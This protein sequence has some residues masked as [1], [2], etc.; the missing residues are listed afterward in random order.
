MS[1][2]ISE[3]AVKAAMDAHNKYYGDLAIYPS[4]EPTPEGAFHEAL[5]AALPF[6][7][8]QGAVKKLAW[9]RPPLSDTL[10]RCDTDFG[11]YRTWTHD[12]ANGKWFWSVEGGW[13]EANGEAPNEDAAKAAA[14]AD[15]S[16]RILSALE[17]SATRELALEEGYRQGIEAAAQKA[18]EMLVFADTTSTADR[19]IPAAIRALGTSREQLNKAVSNVPDQQK[20]EP[21]AHG[22]RELPI[23]RFDSVDPS[24][25]IGCYGGSGQWIEL[26]T[27]ADIRSLSSPDH[28]DAGKVEG[29]GWL[30][31]ESAPKDG[32]EIIYLTKYGSVGF[33]RYDPAINEDD[34]DCWW[35]VQADDEVYPKFWLPRSALPSAPASEGA[36]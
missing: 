5:K 14:Q 7:P 21:G 3:E 25:S 17:P 2:T 29:D 27:V 4:E 20:N 6:L 24:E 16:A 12:E 13:D 10:S 22:E 8:V 34:E 11:T 1:T 23:D 32:T 18:A 33:C 26:G 9:I 35:D 30:P 19:E 31:I 15:Y 36:E 28:A